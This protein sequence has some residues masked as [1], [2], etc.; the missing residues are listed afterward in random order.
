LRGYAYGKEDQNLNLPFILHWNNPSLFPH[1]HLLNL[2]STRESL[3]WALV[4]WGARWISLPALLAALW[5]AAS[6]LV[7]LF[8]FKTGIAW[9]K[10][11][12]AARL[13]VFLWMPAY[14]VPG[15]ANTTFHDYFTTCILG[16]L[17]GLMALCFFLEGKNGRSAGVGG[18][19]VSKARMQLFPMGPGRPDTERWP[20]GR[21]SCLAQRGGGFPP[22]G[23]GIEARVCQKSRKKEARR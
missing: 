7:L 11:A 23:M 9:W 10:R 13:A 22:V 8:T 18:G 1:D 20:R 2:G 14:V 4:A 19:E 17:L 16:T 21:A 15:V 6:C 3:V 5:F 12:E